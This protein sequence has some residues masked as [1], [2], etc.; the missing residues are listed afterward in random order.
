MVAPHAR[1][2]SVLCLFPFGQQL[3]LPE[4]GAGLPPV[5][6]PV[7]AATGCCWCSRGSL[8][9]SEGR[10]PPGVGLRNS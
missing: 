5:S 8:L 7:G 6:D 3:T 4:L 9:V 10:G 2:H 1:L